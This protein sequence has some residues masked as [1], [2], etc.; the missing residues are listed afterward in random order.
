MAFFML[1]PMRVS[2]RS[3]LQR[4][5]VTNARARLGG[6]G[7][8]RGGSPRQLSTGTQEVQEVPSSINPLLHWLGGAAVASGLWCAFG[9]GTVKE[10]PEST[11]ELGVL[12]GKE[13]G[14]IRVCPI[15]GKTT[16]PD[17]VE[18]VIFHGGCK[19]KTSCTD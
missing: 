2:I 1:R 6:R 7:G 19:E 14:L 5:I 3:P 18:I 17:D 11:V 15:V 9:G 12:E 10:E 4:G 13:A 16:Q 8:V